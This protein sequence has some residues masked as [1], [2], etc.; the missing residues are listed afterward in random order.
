MSHVGS[1]D[2]P[3]LFL[4]QL[5]QLIRTRVIGCY[6]SRHIGEVVLHRARRIRTR[7][8]QRPQFAF[9]GPLAPRPGGERVR[10]RGAFLLCS[11]PSTGRVKEGG[12][13]VQ[14]GVQVQRRW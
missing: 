14:S 8:E 1:H 9:S 13:I 5:P 6:L 4:N 10:V 2:R 12:G 11:L 7:L 3:A